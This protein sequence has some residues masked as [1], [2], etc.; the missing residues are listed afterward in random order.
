MLTRGWHTGPHTGHATVVA[1]MIFKKKRMV[2]D[3]DSESS[4][5]LCLVDWL[6]DWLIDVMLWIN[7]DKKVSNKFINKFLNKSHHHS[8]SSTQFPTIGFWEDQSLASCPPRSYGLFLLKNTTAKNDGKGCNICTEIRSEYTDIPLKWS[9]W[10]FQ[11]I[12]KILVN[13]DH[14]PS[15]GWK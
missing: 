4:P 14:F 7:H 11:P 13:L 8:I 3:F 15:L 6:I 2:M 1:N 5:L 10:W 12:W 9:G